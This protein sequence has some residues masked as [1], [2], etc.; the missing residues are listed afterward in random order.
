ML[1]VRLRV[2]AVIDNPVLQEDIVCCEGSGPSCCCR[3]EERHWDAETD[4]GSHY[5]CV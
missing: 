4:F 1:H 3:G 2:Q 5:V